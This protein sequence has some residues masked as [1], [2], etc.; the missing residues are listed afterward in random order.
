MPDSTPAERLRA[1]CE[2]HEVA[3]AMLVARARRDQP[4]ITDGEIDEMVRAWLAGGDPGPGR[5]R[6]WQARE[7]RPSGSG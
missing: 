3:I 6:A 1:T 2:L 4:G 5:P 7:P